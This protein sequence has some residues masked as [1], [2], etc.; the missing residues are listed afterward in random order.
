M[1]FFSIVF[2]PCSFAAENGSSA[3]G[4]LPGTAPPAVSYT[5]PSDRYFSTKTSTFSAGM[6]SVP[7]E[8]VS[9]LTVTS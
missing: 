8:C 3:S 7:F 1:V 2:S 6:V 9:A 5:P 4:Y